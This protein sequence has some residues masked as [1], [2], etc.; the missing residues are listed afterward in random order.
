MDDSSKILSGF[1]APLSEDEILRYLSNKMGSEEKMLLRKRIGESGFDNDAIDGLQQLNNNEDLKKHVIH[2]NKKLH[3]QLQTKKGWQSKKELKSLQWIILAA[4]ILLL[5]CI[6]AF[7]ILKMV[8]S[9]L[10]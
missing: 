4:I 3:Q 1:Q 10:N 7:F 8:P 2:L 6:V 5:L 9:D